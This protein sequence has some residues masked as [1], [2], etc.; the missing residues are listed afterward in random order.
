MSNVLYRTTNH[1]TYI[2]HPRYSGFSNVLEV[3]FSK[4]VYGRLLIP[5]ALHVRFC[6]CH[7]PSPFILAKRQLFRHEMENLRTRDR[8]QYSFKCD[9]VEY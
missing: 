4:Q 5:F 7:S 8:E 1:R 6:A 3:T 9:A 2:A